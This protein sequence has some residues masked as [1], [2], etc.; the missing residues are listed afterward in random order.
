M[1]YTKKDIYNLLLKISKLNNSLNLSFNFDITKINDK[2]LNKLYIN[3]TILY[4]KLFYD[5]IVQ[6]RNTFELI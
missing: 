6:H 4:N 5:E 1:K 2:N 3:L